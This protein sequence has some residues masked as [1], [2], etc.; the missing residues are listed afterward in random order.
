[1]G[2]WWLMH[3]GHTGH[4]H[5]RCPLCMVHTRELSIRRMAESQ[6]GGPWNVTFGQGWVGTDEFRCL[7]VQ[8]PC[9]EVTDH[10]GQC[11]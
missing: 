1:M 5:R 9:R 8:C 4:C 11:S 3:S 7:Q 6:G 10:A 2:T